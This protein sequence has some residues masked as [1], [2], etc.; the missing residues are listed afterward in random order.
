MLAP[1]ALATEIQIFEMMGNSKQTV[2]PELR[3]RTERNGIRHGP[4]FQD[5]QGS[6]LRAHMGK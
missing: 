2:S 3:L 4:G 5:I 1:D 6:E